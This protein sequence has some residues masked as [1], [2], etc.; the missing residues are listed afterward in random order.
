MPKKSLV[1]RLEEGPVICA[2]GYLFELERRG[3]VQ[4]GPFV[5]E[6]VLNYPNAVREL[7]RE[8]L[9]TGSDIIEAFTYY[10]HREKMRL[11]GKEHLVKDLNVKAL[12]IAK[13]VAAEGDA[14]V[15]GNI[16]NTNVWVP[17]NPATHEEAR[18]MFAEQVAWAK[19]ANVDLIVAETFDSYGEA[20][21]ALKEIQKAGIPSVVTFTTLKFGLHDGLGLVEACKKLRE[22]GA[23]VVGFNCAR[24]PE[25]LL[26]LLKQLR[27][28]V[29][30]PI[31]ALPVP[32]RTTQ[33]KPTFQTLSPLHH[34]YTELEPHFLTRY[35]I[36]DYTRQM[37][38]VG[39]N[40]FGLCC[41]NSP[42]LNRAMAEALGKRPPASQYSPD[43]S[44]HF[45]LGDK[46]DFKEHHTSSWAKF[47]K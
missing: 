10:G 27:A 43:L 41:G 3:Y 8:F 25:T 37:K 15:A 24:G 28:E 36:A 42:Y 11:I 17:D 5:P 40:Y 13:E 6:V 20:L 44:K 14:L 29:T 23:T 47:D 45:A 32:Y 26:P 2:E 7:H 9:L 31:A 1:E 38:E 39:V 21:C 4:V 22:E 19:E 12:E 35:E 34:C 30:G 33:E 46:K 18:L 16:C